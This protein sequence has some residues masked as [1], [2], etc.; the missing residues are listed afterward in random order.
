MASDLREGSSVGDSSRTSGALR[1]RLS[2]S[3][4]RGPSAQADDRPQAP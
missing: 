4:D 2:T 1:R 3:V